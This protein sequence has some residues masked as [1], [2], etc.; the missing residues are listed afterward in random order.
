MWML[1]R[2]SLVNS[3]DNH[4]I[5][6]LLLCI[7]EV[8]GIGILELLQSANDFAAASLNSHYFEK[9]EWTSPEPLDWHLFEFPL[10]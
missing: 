5:N 9:S 7:V 6:N 4:H 10:L 1:S 2:S 8:G 3:G